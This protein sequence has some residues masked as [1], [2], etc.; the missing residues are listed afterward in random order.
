MTDL[1]LPDCLTAW[2]YL[3][4]RQAT[5]GRLPQEH[6]DPMDEGAGEAGVILWHHPGLRLAD[7][8]CRETKRALRRK[9]YLTRRYLSRPPI[10]TQPHSPCPA[11]LVLA[12]L[13]T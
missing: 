8:S 9:R 2:L 4:D 7:G 13:A 6:W 1:L 3:G 11:R 10:A 12:V 5:S